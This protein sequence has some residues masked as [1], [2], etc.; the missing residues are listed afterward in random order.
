MYLHR[1]AEKSPQQEF[2]ENTTI[3][4]KPRSLRDFVQIKK[5]N[6]IG[7][8]YHDYTTCKKEHTR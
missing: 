1:I 8:R 6:K 5:K 4:A 3:C 2:K 7:Y